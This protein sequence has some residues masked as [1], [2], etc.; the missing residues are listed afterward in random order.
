M[1]I[2]RSLQKNLGRG[3][4]PKLGRCQQ[5][6]QQTRSYLMQPPTTVIDLA[7]SCIRFVERAVGVRLDDT[8][9]TLSVLDHYVAG[10]GDDAESEVLGLV[11]PAVGA[12]F[13]EVVRKA[14]GD[15]EWVVP[16]TDAGEADY[17][18]WQL[19]F[20]TCS[21]RFNPVGLAYEV[22]TRKGNAG[23]LQVAP[24]DRP[25]VERVLETLGSVRDDDYFRLAVRFEVL[26]AVFRN[27]SETKS[28]SGLPEA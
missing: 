4:P 13:G 10:V 14:W 19:Q 21:L 12:Y 2:T 26:D 22:A 23:L 24:K 7:E 27:L 9:D 5:R 20:E 16:R 11:V 8:P 17:D 28:K 3:P 18:A 15:G 6:R 1:C 25:T